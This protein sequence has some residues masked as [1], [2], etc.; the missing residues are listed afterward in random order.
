MCFCRLNSSSQRAIVAFSPV[1]S[2]HPPLMFLL[3]CFWFDVSRT[4]GAFAIRSCKNSVFVRLLVC[5]I[6]RIIERVFMAFIIRDFLKNLSTRFSFWFRLNKNGF[7]TRSRHFKI[8]GL[9][10]FTAT[11]CTVVKGWMNTV[12]HF[13]V[14]CTQ[15]LVGRTS[16]V[17][18]FS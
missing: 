17:V 14:S 5:N 10:C 3:N 7:F 6:S 9:L 18:I 16:K 13:N 12:L 15:R 2:C 11:Y 1:L 4:F 8:V